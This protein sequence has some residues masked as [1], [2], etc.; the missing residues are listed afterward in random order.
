MNNRPD[1]ETSQ[2]RELAG[3]FRQMRQEDVAE[4]PSFPAQEQLE[5]RTPVVAG[6]AFSGAPLEN[7]GRGICRCRNGSACEQPR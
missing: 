5:L 2:D 7:G 6:T 1:T 3:R 4:A